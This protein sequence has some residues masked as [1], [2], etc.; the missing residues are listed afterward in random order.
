MR[1]AKAIKDLRS[2]NRFYTNIIG[3]VDRHIL[4]SPYSLTEVRILYEIHYDAHSSARKIM[5]FLRV[6][7]G[8]LSRTIDR[9]ISQGLVL[10]KRSREDGRSFILSLSR[11]GEAEFLALNRKSEESMESMIYHLS[12]EEVHELV[13]I[14]HRM[15]QLLTKEQ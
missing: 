7:E 2:F 11:K 5:S 10:R 9:L 6:D 8:Y 15:R 12:S 14:V 4:E 3:V 1:Y 13:S